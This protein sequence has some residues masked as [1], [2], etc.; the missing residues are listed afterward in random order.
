MR[1][2][3]DKMKQAQCLTDAAMIAMIKRSRARQLDQEAEE[4]LIRA[5]IL[6]KECKSDRKAMAGASKVS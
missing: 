4:D 3:E 5:R 1:T 2:A 6:W